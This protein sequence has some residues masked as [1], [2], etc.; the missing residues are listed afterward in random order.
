[1]APIPN[2][3]E[4]RAR[5]ES[6]RWLEDGG[7][8]DPYVPEPPLP[9]E[10]ASTLGVKLACEEMG[11]WRDVEG[12]ITSIDNWNL[13]LAVNRQQLRDTGVLSE[14]QIDQVMV[15]GHELAPAPVTVVPYTEATV[16]IFQ[17][18]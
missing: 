6:E 5:Q 18:R 17:R 16:R 2:A 14:A 13:L 7:V 11:V 1:M 4:N 3:P 10:T 9:I 8:P 15:R 12:A